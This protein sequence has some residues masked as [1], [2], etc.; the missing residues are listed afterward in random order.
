MRHKAGKLRDQ[1]K[2][3][4]EE[5]E[6]NLAVLLRRCAA[7]DST[8][9]HE[10]YI[11]QASHLFGLAMRITNDAELAED[12]VH[13]T[14]VQVWKRAATFD[15]ER[16]NAAAWLTGIVRYRAFDIRRPRARERLV[17][18]FPDQED[19]TPDA[20]A[21]LVGIAE[22]KALHRCLGILE[23]DRRQMLVS[24]YI[25]GLSREEI[26]RKY[27]VPLGTVKSWIRRSLVRLKQCLAP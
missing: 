26:A 7:A 18:D 13:D 21:R 16:G 12:A 27:D 19:E 17:R 3:A 9:L 4:A 5:R 22:A 15:P 14:F 11:R 23:P 10:I 24:A 2:K 1:T 25:D 6:A 8:A 20:L